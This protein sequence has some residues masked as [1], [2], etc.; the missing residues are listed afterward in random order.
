MVDVTALDYALWLC[1]LGASI[2]TLNNKVCQL[3]QIEGS[4]RDSRKTS[5]HKI[6]QIGLELNTSA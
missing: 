4:H 6:N 1:V 2:Q 5:N 3:L